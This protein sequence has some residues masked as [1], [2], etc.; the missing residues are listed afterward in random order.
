VCGDVIVVGGE[1]ALLILRS[2]NEDEVGA[3]PIP[4]GSY[5]RTLEDG[6]DCFFEVQNYDT[7]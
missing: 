1:S 6:T 5:K 2:H 4:N 7:Y 3:I